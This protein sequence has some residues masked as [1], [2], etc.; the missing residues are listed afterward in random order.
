MPEEKYLSVTVIDFLQPFKILG[1][2]SPIFGEILLS[3]IVS[4]AFFPQKQRKSVMHVSKCN[5][6]LDEKS[7]NSSCLRSGANVWLRVYTVIFLIITFESLII[8]V[9]WILNIRV[10]MDK[11][12]W[13]N[14]LRFDKRSHHLVCFHTWANVFVC[15]LVLKLPP[16]EPASIEKSQSNVSC[17]AKI[18]KLITNLDCSLL[19]IVDM[20]SDSFKIYNLQWL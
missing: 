9:G 16:M 2:D 15:K 1:F 8:H 12:F 5:Y 13:G 17:T 6:S 20:N 14:S 19:F 11:S 10:E 18:L 7:L 4:D 3:C